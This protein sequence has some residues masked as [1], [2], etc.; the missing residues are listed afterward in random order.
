MSLGF[1][2]SHDVSSH[3]SFWLVKSRNPMRMFWNHP[4]QSSILSRSYPNIQFE[5]TVWY[6]YIHIYI[7]NIDVCI[8]LINACTIFTYF[9]WS[10]TSQDQHSGFAKKIWVQSKFNPG[11]LFPC[12][13][14]PIPKVILEQCSKPLYHS[15]ESWLVEMGIS[16]YWIMKKSP[17]K[18]EG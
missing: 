16:R 7:Y 15:I 1:T 17:Q 14:N 18:Y 6:I 9:V 11:N 2:I 10:N 12:L 4:G 13:L 3:P 5:V 8:S